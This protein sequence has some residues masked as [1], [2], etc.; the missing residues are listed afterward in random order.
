MTKRSGYNAKFAFWVTEEGLQKI[1]EWASK[2]LTKANVAKN[3]GINEKTFYKWE[4]DHEVIADAY[5]RG[6]VKPDQIVQNKLFERA[7]GTTITEVTEELNEFGDLVIS[8]RVTKQLPPDTTA[9]IFWLKSRMPEQW[10]ESPLSK[11]Q[12]EKIK[13]ETE[14]VKLTKEK[15]RGDKKDTSLLES[16]VD[17]LSDKS[18]KAME[19]EVKLAE[20]SEK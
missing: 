5:R 7:L 19:K 18:F 1:N 17:V 4:K 8:K 14:V 16:L 20:E 13:E 10:R 11:A 12:V 3:I 15:L 9:Q 6:A 2:G